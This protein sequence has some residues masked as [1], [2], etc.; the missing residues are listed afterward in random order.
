MR[1]D[2]ALKPCLDGKPHCF[3]TS[4]EYIEDADLFNADDGSQS[5][6]WLVEPFRFNK[7]LSDAVAD[8]KAAISA[9]PPGQRGIDGGGFK[10][11]K[12]QTGSSAAYFYVQFE[13]RKKGYIDDME[14]VVAP[15]GLVNV[16][17]SSRAGYLDFGGVT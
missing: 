9:Y 17:T 11:V 5:E 2:G 13:S 14:F 12:E 1:K 6:G 7:P 8:I 15:G 16:R 4:A 10:I 3:S